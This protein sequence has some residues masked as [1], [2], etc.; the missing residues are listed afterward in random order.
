MKGTLGILLVVLA[1]GN[2]MAQKPVP[3]FEVNHCDTLE[4]GVVEWPGDRYTWDVYHK[5]PREIFL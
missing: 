4:L 5:I 3:Y 2:A 1:M